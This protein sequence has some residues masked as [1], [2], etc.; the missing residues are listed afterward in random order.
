MRG[1]AG[2]SRDEKKKSGQNPTKKPPCRAAPVFHILP[3]IKSS[4]CGS[5]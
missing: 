2:R 3:H 4:H 1:M 5:G